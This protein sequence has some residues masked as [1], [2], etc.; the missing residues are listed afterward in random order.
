MQA[1]V[2]HRRTRPLSVH[3]AG[4]VMSFLQT[5]SYDTALWSYRATHIRSYNKCCLSGS[6][7]VNTRIPSIGSKRK[8]HQYKETQ[9]CLI[10]Q[11][12]NQLHLIKINCLMYTRTYYNYTTFIE[13]N[14]HATNNCANNVTHQSIN[15]L[16][17]NIIMG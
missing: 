9:K 16:M 4:R 2:P 1:A 13:I 10:C 7:S 6:W 12:A 15:S 14:H 3:S 8:G 5:M 11:L 17:Q